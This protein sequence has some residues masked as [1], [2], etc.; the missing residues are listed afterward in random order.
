[1]KK[2]LIA[3]FLFAL[4]TS[5][6]AMSAHAQEDKFNMTVFPAVQEKEVE[7]NQRTRVQIQFKNGEKT[8][9]TGRV[10][11]ADFIVKDKEGTPVFIENETVPP[12]YAAASWIKPATDFI[13]IPPDD[14]VTVDLFINTPSEIK[15][16][17]NYAIVYFEP[18]TQGAGQTQGKTSSASSIT[19]RIG[20]IVNFSVKGMQCKERIQV[21]NISV[22][23]F[24]EYGPIQ[25]S[26]DILNL[27]DIHETPK[28]YAVISDQF[29]NYAGQSPLAEKRIF[30]ETAKSYTVTGG[31]KY[32]IGR[33]KISIFAA[34]GGGRT[35]TQ[36]IY[37]TVFP[38]KIALVVLLAL[39]LILL[40]LR[41]FYNS[42]VRRE[43]DLSARIEK[44][45]KEIERLKD[46]LKKRD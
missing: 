20:G 46:E 19:P 27:G 41:Y 36:D 4:I 30:P 33:Y 7:A 17:G 24:M 18:S 34:Y 32:M 10:K 37:V 8:T 23:T 44:E 21:S 25:A 38:W 11:A 29:G 2:T 9:V 3:L 45:N 1:M 43:A 28:G 6:G 39:I 12:K 40:A 31:Q 13:T 5:F 14:F 42:I 22:P 26:F 35:I 16:C 15:T